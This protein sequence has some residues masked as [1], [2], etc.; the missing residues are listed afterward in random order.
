[1]NLALDAGSFIDQHNAVARATALLLAGKAF[2]A[3]AAD[4]RIPLKTRAQLEAAAFTL[5]E[6]SASELG[7]G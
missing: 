4:A 3:A 7:R 5:Y 2:L 1:V 6:R